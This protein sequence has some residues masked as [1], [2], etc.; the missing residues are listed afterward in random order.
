MSTSEKKENRL[1]EIVKFLVSGGICWVVQTVFLALL[2]DGLGLDTLIALAIAFL[3]ATVANYLL[4]VLWI[5]PSAKGSGSAVRLGFL[6][7]SLIGLFLNELLMWIF[8]LVFGEDQVLFTV[9]GYDVRQ[10]L[11]NMC[12]VTLLV[13]IWNFF[14]KRAILQSNLIQRLTG[15]K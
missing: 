9:F 8:R 5:W 3:L 4:A 13:M 6:I 11:I 14:T 1:G 12:I 7:T 2:R 10:Y 15:K